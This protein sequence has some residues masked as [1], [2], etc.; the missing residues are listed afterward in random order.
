MKMEEIFIICKTAG[1]AIMHI[2]GSLRL[3]KA[4]GIKWET[5]HIV[6]P[7][8]ISTGS[9][10]K[11]LIAATFNKLKNSPFSSFIEG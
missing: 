6:L 11:I 5:L 4:E 2:T 9:A 1:P 7:E 8:R 3:P 10:K